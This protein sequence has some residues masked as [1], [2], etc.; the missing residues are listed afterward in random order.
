MKTKAIVS[1]FVLMI[2]CG[3]SILIATSAIGK[4]DV[5][6]SKDGILRDQ[7]S[8]QGST[9]DYREGRGLPVKGNLILSEGFE[10]N[11]PPPGW[12]VIQT[13]GGTSQPINSYWSQTDLYY[14]SGGR[15]AGLYWDFGHQ[16]EWLITPI[17]TLPA[18]PCLLSFRSYGYE[19]SSHNDHYWVKVSNDGGA[20][21]T[22]LYNLTA[23][24]ENGWNAWEYLYCVDLSAYAGQTVEI[25]F[26]ADDPPD[27]DGLWY[28]WVI[29]DVTIATA[30]IY[31][32][33]IDQTV[34][35]TQYFDWGAISMYIGLVVPGFQG[36][37]SPSHQQWF[38]FPSD[39]WP[40]NPGNSP[41]AWLNPGVHE[42]TLFG[43]MNNMFMPPNPIVPIPDRNSRLCSLF[44][45][46]PPWPMIDQAL[47]H[48]V[49]Q[50]SSGE[51]ITIPI[52][53][54]VETMVF[55]A[56]CDGAGYVSLD[57]PL[58][59]RIDYNDGSADTMVFVNIHPGERANNIASF[60]Y[61]IYGNEIL[62]CGP[63][64]FELGGPYLNDT[65]SEYWHWYA[66]WPDN[67]KSLSSITFE[68]I[69]GPADFPEIYISALSYSKATWG[70]ALCNLVDL[71]PYWDW[72]AI[73]SY[74]G[75]VPP[76]NMGIWSPSHQT[77]FYFPSD[78]FTVSGPAVPK[79][80]LL[81]D[82]QLGTFY[83]PDNVLIPN[84]P[85]VTIPDRFSNICSLFVDIPQANLIDE[86]TDIN[87]IQICMGEVVTVPI[88]DTVET[89]AFLA[90][91]DGAGYC[92]LDQP[93]EVLLDYSDGSQD[94]VVFADI[95]PGERAN[96]IESGAY[97]IYG[98]EILGCGPAYYDLP[99]QYMDDAHS[100][101]WHWYVIYPDTEVS[102]N[103]I[104]FAGVQ[105]DDIFECIYILALSYNGA[106]C[107]CTPGDA[108]GD[109]AIN[110]GDAGYIINWIF[111]A[112]PNPTPYPLC[113]G[114][115]NCDCAVNLA[116]AGYIINWIFYSGP[117]P[118]SCQTWLSICGP[119]LRK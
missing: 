102:I 72:G 90:N 104:T 114:D 66:I 15:S 98:D 82:V 116:D 87:V 68:G 62:G 36:I 91:C 16:D 113:S 46:V 115:A 18:Q 83:G 73:S 27:N 55:L 7:K 63:I 117:A 67:T 100:E 26:H 64:Y 50:V 84:N 32:K 10:G 34:D 13:H 12:T 45:E 43:P 51:I 2:F 9:S 49:I 54:T 78:S 77:Y 112:G 30:P 118:C 57:Q 8:A 31:G 97:T 37:W 71:S 101:F 76:G 23:F 24:P 74:N 70:E 94:T 52:D 119:P 109:G 86:A 58:E 11:W 79:A 89:M 96:N 85:I 38:Y 39:N 3:F 1:M 80:W 60:A 69:Q 92:S 40:N 41:R 107:D 5:P 14:F 65:H 99:S 47:D 95:H 25:A 17:I 4:G 75:L 21:W 81:P 108:N 110:L 6:T 93:L 33:T 56:N 19:G 105:T 103:D 61:T 106:V 53:D 22:P 59:V 29:D 88:N 111:Y 35:L 48:N 20:N 28:V 44:V 42:G